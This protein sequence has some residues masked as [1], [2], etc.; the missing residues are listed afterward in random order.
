M[1]SFMTV[2]IVRSS[3]ASSCGLLQRVRGATAEARRSLS[4]LRSGATGVSAT[5]LRGVSYCVCQPRL[6]VSRM[7]CSGMQVRSY[8]LICCIKKD[9]HTCGTSP[10]TS[11]PVMVAAHCPGNREEYRREE[12]R[13]SEGR[14]TAEHFSWS[15][16]P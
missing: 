8:G 13:R 11:R 10:R 9:E 4:I 5:A 2:L 16:S 3:T 7:F 15:R 1:C 12:Y 14:T 6:R